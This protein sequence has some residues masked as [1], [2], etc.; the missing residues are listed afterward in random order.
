MELI[1]G[2]GKLDRRVPD[3]ESLLRD[4]R[5]KERDFGALY[6]EH[7]PGRVT[8]SASATASSKQARSRLNQQAAVVDSCSQPA[9]RSSTSEAPFA[10]TA[11]AV[12][13]GA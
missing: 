9:S 7:E 10:I 8:P 2:A 6:L 13:G 3:V 4:W 11:L 1:F 5:E 12:A